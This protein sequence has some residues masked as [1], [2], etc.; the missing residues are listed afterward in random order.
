MKK[1]GYILPPSLRREVATKPR[2][3]QEHCE[4]CQLMVTRGSLVNTLVNR[5]D[6]MDEGTYNFT[7]YR[8]LCRA[9]RRKGGYS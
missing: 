6:R 9:C 8:F 2:F 7:A 1:L 3:N 4:G 5:D